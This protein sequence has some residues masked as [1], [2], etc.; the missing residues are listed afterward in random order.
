M[1]TLRPSK[2]EVGNSIGIIAPAASGAIFPKWELDTAKKKLETLGLRVIY[3]KNV[4][5]KHALLSDGIQEKVDDLH[6][7]F[8]S[9]EVAGIMAIT[10]GYS[11]N[12]LLPH[13]DFELIRKNPKFFIGYSDITALQNAMF[14]KTGLVTFSGPCFANFAQSMPPFAFEE[15]SFKTMAFGKNFNVDVKPSETWADDEWWKDPGQARRLKKNRGWNYLQHGRTK[16]IIVGGN[17]STFL[18]LLGTPYAPSIKDKI[19]FIEEDPEMNRGMIE[20]MFAQLGEQKDIQKIKGLVIG[21]FSS[22][23]G[24]K[25]EEVKRMI[26][27]MEL[28]VNI[29]IM[30]NLDFGHTNPIMTFPIGGTCEIDAHRSLLRLSF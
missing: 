11:S 30:A 15:E 9:K 4:F 18:L 12:Q 26:D 29:P 8:A 19:L 13:L 28:P 21:R 16:G 14:Q 20:R 24:F 23:T 27:A 1:K 5:K 7:M 3:G 17:L 25:D 2:L 6:A 10:G 22:K